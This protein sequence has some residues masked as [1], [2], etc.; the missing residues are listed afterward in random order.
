MALR[1]RSIESRNHMKIEIGDEVNIIGNE[2]TVVSFLGKGKGGY[3]YRARSREGKDY[4]LKCF[5]S[6]AVPYYSFSSP[7][8][9]LEIK[10]YSLLSRR[11]IELPRLLYWDEER[12]ILLKEYIEGETMMERVKKKEDLSSFFP[13]MDSISKVS[14]EN[15]VNLDWFPTNFIEKDNNLYYIDYEVSPYSEEWSFRNWGI[16]YW[17]ESKALRDYLSSH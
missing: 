16:E 15:G 6:E 17:R 11:S 1:E 14:K 10:A 9:T 13:T 4:T 3:S 7:K 12:D 5:H 2:I 8:I